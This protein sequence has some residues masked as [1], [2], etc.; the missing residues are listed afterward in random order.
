VYVNVAG[1]ARIA[2]PAADLAVLLAMISAFRD[3]PLAGDTA[4]FGE[5]GLT[6]EVRPVGQPEARARE[7]AGLGFARLILPAENLARVRKAGIVATLR[8]GETKP[9]QLAAARHL[10]E[11]AQAAMN[12]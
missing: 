3:Q 2:E 8:G 1:G 9:L 12:P 10:R 7:A 6:G 4:V 5:I 11:A